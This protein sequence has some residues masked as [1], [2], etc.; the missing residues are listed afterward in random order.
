[1]VNE[2]LYFFRQFSRSIATVGSFIPTSRFAAHAMVSEM[3][4]R[5][6]PRRILE[7]GPGTGPITAEIVRHMRPDDSLV[8]CELNGD[9]VAFLADRMATDPTFAAR[10]SQITLQHAN[11]QDLDADDRFDFI[12]S[13][14]PFVNC[15]PEVVESILAY[16]RTVLKPDGVLSFIEFAY[17]RAVRLK[18]MSLD[19]REQAE[20]AIAVM[21]RDVD[22]HVFRR[23]L[24]IRNVPPAWVR[25]LR[26]VP[27]DPVDA[28]NLTPLDHTQRIWLGDGAGLASAA[29]PLISVALGL[30]WVFRHARGA[31]LVAWLAAAGVAA[32]FRDPPRKVVPDPRVAFAAA[33]GTVL[34]V[35]EVDDDRFGAGRWLRIAVFLS[36]TDVH[37]NR[38]PIAGLIVDSLDTAGHYAHAGTPAAEHNHARYTVIDGA[39]G[40]CVVAQRVGA[41]ARR[42]VTWTRVGELV[43]QGERYGL[44]CFGSRTDVY[45]AADQWTACVQAGERVVGG[46]SPLARRSDGAPRSTAP[47]TDTGS[48]PPT[49][50]TT[51]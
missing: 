27:P 42:I 49:P 19:A 38:A 24:V 13:A 10:R 1:M 50:S 25:H 9:F 2:K 15:P 51:G 6:G 4:R 44:I 17:L 30:G 41:V 23:D 16:Y 33:D 28:L 14:I 43:S 22:S 36:I 8:L 5:T 47:R 31:P 40:R 21:A 12:I 45:V 29:V 32:F 46:I 37:I 48:S 11:V 3:A 35:E 26:F 39:A 20:A 34:S 18:M 7:V